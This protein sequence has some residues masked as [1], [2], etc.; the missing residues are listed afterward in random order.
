MG[1]FRIVCDND[2][3][4]NIQEE[5]HWEFLAS[6]ASE[7]GALVVAGQHAQHSTDE[8]NHPAT[9]SQYCSRDRRSASATDQ[10]RQGAH[11]MREDWETVKYPSNDCWEWVER[12]RSNGGQ[13]MT[14]R[15]FWILSACVVLVALLW[16]DPPPAPP[17]SSATSEEDEDVVNWSVY[18]QR[19]GR[20]LTESATALGLQT[21]F[22]IVSWLATSLY[23]DI[24]L[25]YEQYQL[26][27]LPK[28]KLRLSIQDLQFQ[29]VRQ[30]LAAEW[31]TEAVQARLG[32]YPHID[33]SGSADNIGN[34]PWI[35]WAIGY[36]HTGKR[37]LARQLASMVTERCF[38]DNQAVLTI[39]GGDWRGIQDLDYRNDPDARTRRLE[40]VLESLVTNMINHIQRYGFT[41]IVVSKAEDMDR[42]LLKLF[43][44]SLESACTANPWH[45]NKQIL[46]H[47]QGMCGKSILYL[48]VSTGKALEP[49]TRSLRLSGEDLRNASAGLPADLRDALRQNIGV[50]T[51]KLQT[52]LPFGPMTP[53]GLAELLRQLV[54]EYSAT[55]AGVA[56]KELRITDAAEQSF[57]HPSRVEYLEW[58]SR[59]TIVPTASDDEQ[60]H[61]EEQQQ[62]FLM[63][64][65]LEGASVLDDRG[66]VMTKIY[67]QTRPLLLA[68][69]AQPNQVAVLD[70]DQHSSH[71]LWASNDEHQYRG[72]LRWCDSNRQNQCQ[73]VS[74]F[75]I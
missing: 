30:P 38:D 29:L 51:T 64:V 3:D 21:P 25:Y 37:T 23:T 18:L 61:P 26:H 15:L 11:H 36:P 54:A 14:S 33:Q 73:T 40:S 62:Q 56:W 4:D 19:H 12:D 35:V 67:A 70:V 39:Q 58:K 20:Q 63:T 43:L 2:D 60:L 46:S 55:H 44:Q 7:E 17:L 68:E 71:R 75:R 5:P 47:F 53:R 45:D 66:P 50:D 42:D 6:E 65:A 41:V 52:L 32:R 22:H 49:I 27:R 10:R 9:R 72:V 57:L 74:R 34:E 1:R 31:L 48:T 16:K 59:S 28:C 69:N 24:Q 8:H 13:S